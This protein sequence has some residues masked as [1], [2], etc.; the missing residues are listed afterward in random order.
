MKLHLTKEAA[1]SLAGFGV[2]LLGILLVQIN[3]LYGAAT[4]RRLPWL[5][6]WKRVDILQ[7]CPR[8]SFFNWLPT[9]HYHV[10]VRDLYDLGSGGVEHTPWKL[11]PL[12]KRSLFRVVWNPARRPRFVLEDACR[13]LLQNLGSTLQRADP[14]SDPWAAADPAGL[15]HTCLQH[16]VACLPASPLSVSRQF[17]IAQSRTLGASTLQPTPLFLSAPFNLDP[18]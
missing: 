7:L 14:G 8:F 13:S 12:P 11:L 2:W 18:S 3:T 16:H 4:Q 5:L 1:L 15:A 17:L 10:L 6:R 9:S